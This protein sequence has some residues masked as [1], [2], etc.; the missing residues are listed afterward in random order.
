[1]FF[2]VLEHLLI[3][4]S[5]YFSHPTD[6][7]GY[8]ANAIIGF[9][10]VGVNCFLLITGFFGTQF[11]WKKLLNLYFVCAFYEL[12]FFV[13]YLLLGE[14]TFSFS[15]LANVVFPLSH[16][17]TWFIRCYTLLLL[18]SPL[19]NKGLESLDKKQFQYVL[20]LF[21]IANI[22]FGWFWKY[23][24]FNRVEDAVTLECIVPALH[25]I[26]RW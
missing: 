6:R 15:A 7:Q 26:M 16:S 24:Q 12:L 11:S 9:T 5:E 17:G 13:V 1:M 21:T 2:I 14:T 25:I 10:Y 4:G 22:Y 3:N 8:V 18:F 19:I 20:L 23:P